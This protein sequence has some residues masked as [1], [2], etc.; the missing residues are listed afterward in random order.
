ME[1][2]NNTPCKL[3]VEVMSLACSI[4][5]ISEEQQ[6]ACPKERHPY[7]SFQRDSRAPY[8]HFRKGINYSPSVLISKNFIWTHFYLLS[9]LKIAFKWTNKTFFSERTTVEEAF[10]FLNLAGKILNR[11]QEVLPCERYTCLLA[12]GT[13]RINLSVHR[14]RYNPLN[15]FLSDFIKREHRKNKGYSSFW[16]SKNEGK[17]IFALF[18]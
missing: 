12:L 11:D 7:P 18:Y 4:S 15:G 17:A 16:P 9:T 2:F 10:F 3:S 5:V 1:K 6:S 13:C 8:I 14:V